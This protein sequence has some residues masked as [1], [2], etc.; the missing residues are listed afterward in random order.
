MA[1]PYVI[2]IYIYI[3][4]YS[5]MAKPYL[6]AIP[7]MPGPFSIHCLAGS[8]PDRRRPASQPSAGPRGEGCRPSDQS[9]I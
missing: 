1:I 3:I 8:A 4:W 5:S 2:A 9:G 7:R 6:I